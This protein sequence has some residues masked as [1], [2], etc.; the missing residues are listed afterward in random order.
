M[1]EAGTSDQA[2]LF[3][4]RLPWSPEH[5]LFS[6]HLLT[7]SLGSKKVGHTFSHLVSY[8]TEVVNGVHLHRLWGAQLLRERSPHAKTTR[9]HSHRVRD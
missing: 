5:L 2:T 9:C 7:F 6:P 8:P 4:G 1:L 3:H